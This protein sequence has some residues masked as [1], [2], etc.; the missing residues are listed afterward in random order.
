MI[1]VYNYTVWLTYISFLSSLVGIYF[2]FNGNS[3]LAII[4]LMLSGFCDMFD[5]KVARMKKD[6]TLEEKK[7]GIQI[8]SLADL[9]AFGVLPS[10]IGYS[11]GVADTPLVFTLFML[12]LFALIRLAYFNVTE[13]ERSSKSTEVRSEYLGLPVTSTA[14]IIPV[15]Y[16]LKNV[17]SKYFVYLYGVSLLIISILFVKK[18][19][20]I[21]LKTKGMI[22]LTVVGIIVLTL[23]LIINL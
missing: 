9:V 7:F 20:V 1:G 10:A 5:G 23:L 11:L 4:C 15:I 14:I 22:G 21:K 16:V 12:P 2:S 13:E 8:D 6:R 19:K 3:F 18:F 17:L